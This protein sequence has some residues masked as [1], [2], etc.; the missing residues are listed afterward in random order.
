M[1]DGSDNP[2]LVKQRYGDGT[3]RIV[4]DRARDIRLDALGDD[5]FPGGENAIPPGFGG[6]KTLFHHAAHPERAQLHRPKA[7]SSTRVRYGPR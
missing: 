5:R 6:P 4:L 1:P 3:G 2:L 7:P